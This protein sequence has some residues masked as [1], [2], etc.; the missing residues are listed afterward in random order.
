MVPHFRRERER[1]P[2]GQSHETAAGRTAA[3][4][5]PRKEV[6]FFPRETR[7]YVLARALNQRRARH[8]RGAAE[9]RNERPCDSYPSSR[10][11]PA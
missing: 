10:A 9:R 2:L 3:W 4:L 7:R 6:R 1:K 5:R 8:L 11:A